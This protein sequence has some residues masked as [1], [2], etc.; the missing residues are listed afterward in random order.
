MTLVVLANAR[1]QMLEV[2]LTVP[3]HVSYET[4]RLAKWFTRLSE[5]RNHASNLEQAVKLEMIILHYSF[6]E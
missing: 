4:Y 5:I 2:L 3:Q 1:E 6:V